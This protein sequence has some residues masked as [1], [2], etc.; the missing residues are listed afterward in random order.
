MDTGGEGTADIAPAATDAPADGDT[1]GDG[2]PPAKRRKTR[3]ACQ[4][5]RDRKV[6]CDGARP[7]CGACARK[8]V[9]P[10]QCIFVDVA[11]PQ[12]TSDISPLYVRSLEER[13]HELER[14]A[15]GLDGPTQQLPHHVVGPNK[16][17]SSP[18]QAPTGQ[19]YDEIQLTHDA[20][21]TVPTG[22]GAI[23]AAVASPIDRHMAASQLI[24][25]QRLGRE[26][27]AN[28]G[29]SPVMG[30]EGLESPEPGSAMGATESASADSGR[31]VFLGRSSAAAFVREVRE[32]S[33]RHRGMSSI[34]SEDAAGLSPSEGGTSASHGASAAPRE[35]RRTK[36]DR[37]ALELL[38]DELILPPRRVADTHLSKYWESFHPLFPV[39]HKGSFMGW[40]ETIWG[41]EEPSRDDT[42]HTVRTAHARLNIM[43]ALGCSATSTLEPGPSSKRSAHTFYERS[44]TL[45]TQSNVDHGCSLQ[46]VQAHILTAQYLQATDLVN[47]CWVAIGTAVRTAQGIGVSED[48]PRESQATREE[49]RRTWW[50]CIMLDRAVSMILGRPPMVAWKTGV[51]S[52]LPVDDEILSADPGSGST[53]PSMPP[54]RK[55]P[56]EFY[57]YTLQLAEI[58][59]SV[60]EYVISLRFLLPT[61][62]D[63]QDH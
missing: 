24:H 48:H 52:P 3:L 2:P 12:Q 43:L 42:V 5:C 23:S 19:P 1:A 11:D 21:T 8:R 17:W 53:P 13:I 35:R 56:V 14:A 39:V 32:S 44:R 62:Q 54:G 10:E 28:T 61:F 49:R 40:Y 36:R 33:R 27:S 15:R 20:S 63:G 22:P 57:V 6:R 31:A 38:M 59:M 50:G 30:R 46:L 29:N 41:D 26:Q 7:M 58:L 47:G 9:S 4:E 34:G 18:R 45:L 51:P 60:L 55:S 37:E 16:Q 25:M